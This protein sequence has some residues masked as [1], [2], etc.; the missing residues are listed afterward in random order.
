MEFNCGYKRNRYLSFGYTREINLLL[1]LFIT[2]YK[3][4]DYCRANA[5]KKV[6]IEYNAPEG[7]QSS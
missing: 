5:F 7:A 2:G 3:S 1:L 4:D 6:T